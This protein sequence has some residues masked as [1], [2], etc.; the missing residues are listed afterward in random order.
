MTLTKIALTCTL[1]LA[2]GSASAA[3]A[4]Q[5][6]SGLGVSFD[7]LNNIALNYYFGHN[8]TNV[9]GLSVGYANRDV[10][11]ATTALQT[12]TVNIPVGLSV[13]HLVSMNKANNLFLGFGVGYARNLGKVKAADGAY[14]TNE[15]WDTAL[16]IG[17]QYRLSPKFYINAGTPIITY[18]VNKYKGVDTKITTTTF[19]NVS[20]GATF[21]F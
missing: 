20:V 18:G 7:T 21:M 6:K 1:A 2:I 16:H 12:D 15:S 4:A 19:G 11:N 10:E 17:V 9:V 8:N 5:Y 13:S 14:K 3:G